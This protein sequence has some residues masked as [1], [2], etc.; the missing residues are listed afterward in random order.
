MQYIGDEIKINIFKYINYPLNLALTC[1]NWS[2]IIKNPYA[3]SEWLIVNYGKAHA[4]F[5]A[6]RLGP[7]FIDIAVC[8]TLIARDVLVATK[9]F[10]RRLI[11]HKIEYNVDQIRIHP[12]QQKIKL[13][14][15]SNLPVSV[16]IYLLNE[17]YKQ[18]S[19]ENLTSKGNDIH[20]TLQ[21]SHV[22]NRALG[23][24]NI[25]Y[26]ED[27]ILNKRSTLPK[28]SHLGLN[29]DPQQSKD[30]YILR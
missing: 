5:H 13:L 12:F 16:I 7:T 6:I 11:Q 8:Q 14:Y 27:L 15:V 4:L 24:N 17:G 22:I 28:A 25:K 10:I 19:N 1:R 30:G 18:L 23:R 26:F 29:S 3:K 2:V 21:S 9:H 20:V